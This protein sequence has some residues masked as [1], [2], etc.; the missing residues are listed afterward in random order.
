MIQEEGLLGSSNQVL[1]G[2]ILLVELL[3]DKDIEL[4]QQLNLVQLQ[5]QELVE[6]CIPAKGTKTYKAHRI[7]SR[8]QSSNQIYISSFYLYYGKDFDHWMY[9][10]FLYLSLNGQ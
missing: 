9:R 10:L 2:S 5:Y 4:C 8:E 3:L 1:E 7:P 6:G